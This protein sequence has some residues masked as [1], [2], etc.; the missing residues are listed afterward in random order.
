LL[1]ILF[2]DPLACTCRLIKTSSGKGQKEIKEKEYGT[3]YLQI[4]EE[5]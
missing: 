4:A 3:G 2:R 5:E 1:R